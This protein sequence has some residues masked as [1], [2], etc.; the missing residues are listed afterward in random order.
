M[1]PA[2][3]LPAMIVG[4]LNS[5]QST[6]SVLT[7]TRRL[8]LLTCEHNRQMFSLIFSRKEHAVTHVWF[9]LYIQR[10]EYAR[11]NKVR[12]STNNMGHDTIVMHAFG[13]L[14]SFG[15]PD[16]TPKE[17]VLYTPVRKGC[18]LPA[19]QALG[20]FPT[21]TLLQ[22]CPG[23]S[24]LVG[25]SSHICRSGSLSPPPPWPLRSTSPS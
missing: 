11:Q 20:I 8:S 15:V 2:L 14:Q 3:T 23:H 22:S 19:L 12:I 9:L 1:R 25:A 21:Q 17:Y 4:F 10:R 6:L 7:R 24:R 13:A 18:S 5:S 16:K